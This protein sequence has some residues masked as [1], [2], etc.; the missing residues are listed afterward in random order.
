MSLRQQ[1][2]KKYVSSGIK[3]LKSRNKILPRHLDPP[4]ARVVVTTAAFASEVLTNPELIEPEQSEFNA[5]QDS[6]EAPVKVD[7]ISARSSTGFRRIDNGELVLDTSFPKPVIPMPTVQKTVY[8]DSQGRI[9][10]I[11]KKKANFKDIEEKKK[12]SRDQTEVKLSQ[13]DQI[14]QMKDSMSRPKPPEIDD[15]L[16]V[17]KPE[18]IVQAP[19]LYREY[20]KGVHPLNRFNI[21]AGYFWDGIDRSNGFEE[22]LMRKRNEEKFNVRDLARNEVYDLDNNSE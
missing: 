8:R 6:E 3:G 12:T 21:K 19:Q 20:R 4:V 15:P 16:L 5:D 22:L 11:E 13:A 17:F 2:L 7:C 9:I 10:D 1:Y 18:A 14:K